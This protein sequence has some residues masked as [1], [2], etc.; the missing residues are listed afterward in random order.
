MNYEFERNKIVIFCA[1]LFGNISMFGLIH[2]FHF[3]LLS[4]LNKKLF[5]AVCEGFWESEVPTIN[6][7]CR[8]LDKWE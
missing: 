5:Q 8:G 4:F 2:I 3:E 7:F 1:L 6:K